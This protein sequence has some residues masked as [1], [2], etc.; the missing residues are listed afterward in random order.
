MNS[1]KVLLVVLSLSAMIILGCAVGN[2]PPEIVS[3][4]IPSSIQIDETV[5]LSVSAWDPDGDDLTYDW[6]VSEGTLTPSTGTVVQWT[7]PSTSG[8]VTIS[9]IVEDKHG[10]TDSEEETIYVSPITTTIIDNNYT[11]SAQDYYAVSKVLQAGYSVS[12]SFSV[13]SN[14][15]NFYVMDS[16]NYNKWVN[17][18]FAYAKVIIERSTGATFGFDVSQTDTYYFVM[19][20]TYSI[21]TSKSVYL[22][23]TTTSP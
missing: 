12:G 7:A 16:E 8:N 1:T 2:E 20:N 11:I 4:N 6:Y 10:A 18:Q 23:V 14:D 22:K 5:T 13:A 15:I 21:F 9:V 19:D 17:G 3:V